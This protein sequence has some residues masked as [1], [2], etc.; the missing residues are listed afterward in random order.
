MKPPYHRSKLRSES[1][2]WACLACL[3]G[4]VLAAPIQEP[5]ESIS[6]KQRVESLSK[7]LD[8]DKEQQR[9][10]AEK[11]L[12]EI[13]PDALEFLP[14]TDDLA[15]EEWTMRIERIR[16]RF[17][18]DSTF[19]FHEP[20][21]VNIQGNLS[22]FEALEAIQKQTRNPIGLEPFRGQDAFQEKFDFDIQGVT[23]WEAIDEV[24]GKI[25][26]QITPRDGAGLLFGPKFAIPEGQAELLKA[27]SV[28]PPPAIYIG[29]LRMQ[30]ISLS[31][32]MNF[33]DPTQSTATL[34]FSLHWEP[35]FHPV[36]VRFPMDNLVVRT[37]NSELLLVPKDQSSEYV[38]SG[39]QMITSMRVIKPTPA[40]LKIG[41]WKGEL[42]I[43]V[44]GRLST[45]E[46]SSPTENSGKSLSTGDMKVVLESARKNRDLQEIQIGVSLANQ[47]S[48]DVL[49]G[50]IAL[51]DAYLLDKDG[52][53]IEHAGW[54]TTR[55]TK[56]D[57]GLSYLFDIEEDLSQYRFVYKAPDS[58]ILQTVEYEF[59]NIP[60]P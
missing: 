32:S 50:W 44:P 9:D 18:E 20:A 3:T 35:R 6:L 38:P 17:V 30:P 55:L 5:P 27:I 14:Q 31:K 59:N 16:A 7:E 13:G 4:I 22:V 40:A 52:K 54:A 24:L 34:E 47:P 33:L 10:A 23:F 49:Q 26:W 45:I 46:F 15:S 42:Q 12:L 57:I 37:D 8:A 36:F 21:M 48:S 60:F 56:N 28:E 53:K 11:A 39:S 19:D 41:S 2:F 51:T 1:L 29:I 43:A 58:V 25:N